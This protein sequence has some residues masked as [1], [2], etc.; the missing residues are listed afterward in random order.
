MP[1]VQKRKT[2]QLLLD[3][4]NFEDASPDGAGIGN[5]RPCK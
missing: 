4:P 5:G 2:V 3:G 1:L